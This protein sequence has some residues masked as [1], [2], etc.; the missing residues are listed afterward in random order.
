M[1]IGCILDAFTMF[2]N[3]LDSY[4][5]TALM[6]HAKVLS[7]QCFNHLVPTLTPHMH[8]PPPFEKVHFS[9]RQRFPFAY[10]IYEAMRALAIV[11]CHVLI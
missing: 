11:S 6:T 4:G 5:A 10:F 8:I 1:C 3:R 9:M 7:P 2:L